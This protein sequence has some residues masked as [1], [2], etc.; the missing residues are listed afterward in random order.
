L[1]RLLAAIEV[2]RLVGLQHPGIGS[3][4]GTPVD[5][6]HRIPSGDITRGSADQVVHLISRRH[7]GIECCF[8][9]VLVSQLDCFR[10]RVGLYILVLF[11]WIR[12]IIGALVSFLWPQFAPDP[13][14]IAM[15]YQHFY[16]GVC[17]VIIFQVVGAYQVLLKRVAN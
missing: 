17:M 8:M 12:P 14:F 6:L 11:Y 3:G 7:L 2:L 10:Y 16:T 9:F 5:R 1:W 13:V 15:P 4:G